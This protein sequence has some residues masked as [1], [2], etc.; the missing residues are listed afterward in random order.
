VAE[1]RLAVGLVFIPS[2]IR[3]IRGQVLAVR[4][5]TY[6][7]AARS[8][9][10]PSGRIAARHVL[11]NVASP[12][13]IQVAVSL[14]FALLARDRAPEALKPAEAAVSLAP[15][16]FATH[17]VLGRA[18][19]AT[20]TLERGIR[21]LEVAAALAPQIPEIQLTLARACAQAGRKADAERANAR[22]QALESVRRG[23]PASGASSPKVP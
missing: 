1:V 18:L 5:E 11:P 3:L 19:V 13:I 8:V 15:G 14:G 20:G 16:L 9:G 7:E 4:E 6:I 2:L 12:L 17:L 10:T 23:A 22:F 21:E